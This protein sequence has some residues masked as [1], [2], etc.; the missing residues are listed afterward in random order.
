M[1]YL[2]V[3]GIFCLM[4]VGCK[5]VQSTPKEEMNTSTSSESSLEEIAKEKYP[6]GYRIKTNEPNSYSLIIGRTK[7]MHDLFPEIEFSVFEHATGTIIF[8]DRLKAGAVKWENEHQVQAIARNL[9]EEDG[10]T[11]RMYY[12][13]VRT[14]KKTEVKSSR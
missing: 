9:K 13:D 1:K 6:N 11:R 2:F 10:T 8:E 12:Y 14:G 4:M 7:A 5:S 3:L